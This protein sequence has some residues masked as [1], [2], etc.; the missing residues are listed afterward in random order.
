M[1][2]YVKPEMERVELRLEER[3]AR[4]KDDPNPGVTDVCNVPGNNPGLQ[5]QCPGGS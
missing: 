5:E 4:C 3:I 1:K 2:E